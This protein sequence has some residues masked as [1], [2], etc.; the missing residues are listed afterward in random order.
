MVLTM[1][2]KYVLRFLIVSTGKDYSINDVA[3]ACKLTPNGA[4]KLL[5]KLEREGILKAK[6]IANIKSYKLNFESEKTVKVLELALMP[7]A[8]EGRMKLR[9]DDLKPLKAI[10][11]ACILFGSYI[12]NKKEPGDL[13]VL[14][15]VEKKDFTAYKKT[16]LK[17]QDIT[18]IKIQDI[19]QTTEDIDKN[20]R[21]EDPII[22]VS[23]RDGIVLWGFDT[24][25]EVIKNVSQ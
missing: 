11:K 25:V 6:P 2:E 16:L 18:P 14:F 17:V 20:L 7:D 15:I 23:L 8:I 24:L 9:A 5:T 21:K 13:D 10:T 4:Y 1:N 3:K 19:V 12:T 22:V